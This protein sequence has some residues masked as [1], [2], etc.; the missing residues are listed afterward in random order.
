MSGKIRYKFEW[1][2]DTSTRAPVDRNG[3]LTQP[4]FDALLSWLDPD[5]EQ[6]APK[7]EA[8]R[9]RL[10]R[11]FTNRGSLDAEGLA[12]ETIDRVA[13][14]LTDLAGTYSGDPALY[15]CGVARNV[16]RESLKR[17]PAALV[18]HP[19]AQQ[20]GDELGC[21]EKCMDEF[22]P[23]TR[24]LIL[25][26]YED[27]GRAKIANRKSLAGEL[28]VE[29]NALRIRACRIRARLQACVRRCV[30]DIREQAK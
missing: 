17:R 19:P 18:S 15:F 24:R 3:T 9:K 13:R 2:P 6:A 8:I 14:K 21:L 7:Y 16:F 26:Y 11:L 12:D 27:A 23:E 22:P 29:M 10:V 28:G 1:S 4:Q 5:R 20:E 25:S 30:R